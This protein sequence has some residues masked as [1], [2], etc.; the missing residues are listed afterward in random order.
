LAGQKKYI[1][2]EPLLLEGT[3]G[4][5]ARKDRI[6]VP[7]RYHVDRAREWMVKLYED[8]GKPEKAAEW[9]GKRDPGR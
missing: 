7:D 1:E 9:R 2:A 4:M 3:Q 8:W 5:I 6:A